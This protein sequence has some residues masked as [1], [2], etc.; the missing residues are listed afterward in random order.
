MNKS[1]RFLKTSMIYML[2]IVLSK[3]ITFF[4]LP[5]Y[6]S[7]LSPEEFGYYDLILSILNFLVPI[8]YF[9][10]WDGMFRFSFDYKKNEEKY[11]VISN[12]YIVFI[13]GIIIY[14]LIVFFVNAK[15][16]LSYFNLVFIYGISFSINYLYSFIA[17]TFLKNQLFVI[18]GLVNTFLASLLNIVLIVKFNFGVESL[19]ISQS[20]G[21]LLQAL[22]IE[23]N[24]KSISKI[25]F[26]HYN[27]NIIKSMLQFSI[28]LCVASVSYWLLTGFTKLNIN[29][30]L[31]S[32]D[33]GIYSVANRFASLI[34]LG[35][36]V[37]QYAW[38]EIA[39]SISNDNNRNSRYS[40][41]LD[42]LFKFIILGSSVLL[43]LIKWVFPI[44]IDGSY[45]GAGF[46]IPI[47]LFGVAANS[48]AGFIGTIFSSEKK[49]TWTFWST[50]IAS[51]ANILLSLLLTKKYGLI[52]ASLSLS[53]SFIILSVIRF[54]ILRIN[55]NVIISVKQYLYI[56]FYLLVTIIYNIIKYEYLPFVIVVT[57]ILVIYI[58]RNTLR[59]LV[60]MIND[61]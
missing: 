1:K 57:I 59:M 3:L 26:A 32:F 36:S 22:I 14:T 42:M 13:F 15:Y 31:G 34:A 10:I 25:E 61:K 5:M 52:G 49:T 37:F 58:L 17:R 53:I 43:L 47:T 55:F 41:M 6:T 54:I 29:N 19:F 60:K 50:I 46:I 28:P 21:F 45:N 8:S 9:Q 23:F 20:V 12:T 24:V 33:N 39:Y 40:V 44:I 38:N 30:Q 48:I 18:S 11:K 35:V 7:Y 51:C 16:N 4:L 2:G 56:L 27:I